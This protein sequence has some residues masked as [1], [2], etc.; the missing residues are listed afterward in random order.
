[1]DWT[2]SKS[3]FISTKTSA[4]MQR[5]FSSAI[6]FS[7]KVETLC[8]NFVASPCNCTLTFS[9]LSSLFSINTNLKSTCLIF[10]LILWNSEARKTFRDFTAETTHR[11]FQPSTTTY[12]HL[13]QITM[14]WPLQ[15]FLLVILFLVSWHH[16]SKMTQ[17]T[18]H[19][20]PLETTLTN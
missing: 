11:R 19:F 4:I 6:I 1:M 5:P 18:K 17:E 9:I 12:G 13:F 8:F 16:L 14:Y 3:L 20:N 7:S 10:S 2:T 15:R